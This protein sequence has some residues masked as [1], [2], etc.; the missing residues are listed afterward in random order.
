MRILMMMSSSYFP[1]ALQC[2][3]QIIDGGMKTECFQ[4]KYAYRG[5]NTKA[6]HHSLNNS[7]DCSEVDLKPVLAIFT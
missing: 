2:S 7:I 1:K 6:Q 5:S 4:I 3:F